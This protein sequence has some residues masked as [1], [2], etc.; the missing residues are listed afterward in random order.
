MVLGKDHPDKLATINNL[1]TSLYVQGKY[2]GAEA[3]H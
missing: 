3:I 1:V 2:T